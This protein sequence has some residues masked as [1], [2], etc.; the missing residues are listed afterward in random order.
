MWATL[1]SADW[2]LGFTGLL[3]YLLAVVTFRFPIAPYAIGIMA[4][5]VLTHRHKVISTPFATGLFCI[6]IWSVFGVALSE[7]KQ[8]SFDAWIEL[9]KVVIICFLMPQVLRNRQTVLTALLTHV[10]LF[11]L[12]PV[13]GSIFNRLA[14]ETDQGRWKWNYSYNNPNDFA[15]L[16]VLAIG[17][18]VAL[19]FCFWHRPFVRTGLIGLLFTFVFVVV[20]TQSRGVGIGLVVGMSV[21]ALYASAGVR[22][23]LLVSGAILALAAPILVPQDVLNRYFATAVTDDTESATKNDLRIDMARGSTEERTELLKIGL[24][25]ARDHPLFG[26]GLGAYPFANK[27]YAPE[28]GARDTHNTYVNLAAEA[29]IPALLLFLGLLFLT[30]RPCHLAILA[31]R[32]S[33][34]RH[35]MAIAGMLSALVA[36]LVAGLFGSYAKLLFLYVFVAFMYCLSRVLVQPSDVAPIRR[37]KRGRAL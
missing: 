6:L 12:Y 24:R 35:S 18:V 14:G 36:F 16:T 11:A 13:R 8:S 22:K 31:L 15:S 4:F 21:F 3:L 20:M 27:Q 26:V 37:A 9:G 1:N 29:G 28:K 33:Q 2:G 30:F 19:L 10:V 17:S 5:G 23:T 7:W 32:K 25:I 34:P